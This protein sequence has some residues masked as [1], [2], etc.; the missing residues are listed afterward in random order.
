MYEVLAP[1]GEAEGDEVDIKD[2]EDVEALKTAPNPQL[3]TA[4]EIEDHRLIHV[5]FRCWCKWCI[6]GRGL[7]LQHGQGL[8]SWIAIVGLDYFFITRGGPKKRSE[9][10][11][12]MDAAG[13]VALAEARKRGDVI[14]CILLRCLKTKIIFAHVVPYKGAGEDQFVAS[15]VVSDIAWLGHTKLIVK[16]DNEPA[17]QTLVTQALEAVR[18]RCDGVDTITQEHPA[19]YDSQSNGGVEVGVRFVRGLFRTLKLC[20]EARLD[21]YVP[22]NHALIPWLLQHTC[23]V[24][25]VRCRGTDG[26]SAWMRARGR[27]F[28]QRLVGFAE[29]VLYKLPSKG[30]HSQPD[31]NMGALWA[32]GIF[33]GYDRNSNTYIIGNADGVKMSR[34]L[35]RRPIEERWCADTAAKL[36]AT[37]WSLYERPAPEARFNDPALARDEPVPVAAPPAVRRMRIN[38][39]DLETYGYTAGCPQCRHAQAY[40]TARPGGSHTAVCRNRLFEAMKATEVGR[41]RIEGYDERVN[42]NIAERIEQA[43]KAPVPVPPQPERAQPAAPPLE[44][45]APEPEERPG[46]SEPAAGRRAPAEHREAVQ[47]RDQQHEAQQLPSRHPTPTDASV[48]AASDD[49]AVEEESGPS[50]ERHDGV[51]DMSMG[52]IGSLE[53]AHDDVISSVLLQQLGSVGRRYKRESRTAYKKIVSEIYSPPRITR[54]I[55]RSRG[56]HL[57]AGFAMDLTVTDPDDGLPWDFTSPAKQAKARRV[58]REQKPY[59]LIGS[60]ECRMFS[61]WQAL[62][63][64]KNPDKEEIKRAYD[65]AVEHI[66]FVVSLY[67]EQIQGGRYFLHEHPRHATS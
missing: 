53:P 17:L 57:M 45:R 36:T 21:K 65:A 18:V 37:P 60:P 50:E 34:S 1:F 43:D 22:I 11:F 39:S 4:K 12:S 48:P 46:P 14:K 28:N 25:N 3:P 41:Q 15:L 32:D 26:L 8:A 55:R 16:S 27:P 58:L 44:P 24:L 52:F 9:L 47:T 51:G 35:A 66:N 29:K 40:G 63:N 5:P 13:E 7:G 20:V 62:N 61:T 2:D 49:M 59:F 31:G 6:M 38:K 10:E 33:L 56:R 23:L 67:V 64:S 19:A 54:E 42:R 30:P